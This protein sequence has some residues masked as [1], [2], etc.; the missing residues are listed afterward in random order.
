MPDALAARL[1][2]VDLFAGLPPRVISRIVESGHEA[3][4]APGTPVVV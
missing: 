2:T 3:A 1:S 4:Y